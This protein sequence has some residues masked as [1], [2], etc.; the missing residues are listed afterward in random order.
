MEQTRLTYTVEKG[1]ECDAVH[2]VP[3]PEL[4]VSGMAGGLPWPTVETEVLRH[5]RIGQEGGPLRKCPTCERTMFM[6]DWAYCPW[7]GTK[8]PGEKAAGEAK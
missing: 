2:I 7:C 1:K 8:L 4:S 3:R 6:P 5:V